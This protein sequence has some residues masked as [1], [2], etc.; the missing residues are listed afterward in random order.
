MCKK[1][2]S[3]VTFSESGKHGLGFKLVI[4]CHKFDKIYIPSSPFVEKGYE[5]NRRIILAMRLVCVGLNG[6]MKFCAFMDLP[7]PIFQSFYDKVVQRIAVGAETVCQLISIKNAVR[8]EKEK[9]D[10]K[11][12]NTSGITV[13]GDGSWRKRDFSDSYR[14]LDGLLAKWL[15][16]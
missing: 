14:L 3:G 10:E 1:C 15:M 16:F 7:R 8:E 2:K 13:S 5:I 4:S 11:V 9:S 12:M 6:I